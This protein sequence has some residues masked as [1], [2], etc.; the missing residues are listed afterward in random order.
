MTELPMKRSHDAT[1]EPSPKP[2]NTPQINEKD[3]G[4]LCFMNAEVP[5]FNGIIKHRYNDFHVYEVD[6]EG[7]IVHLTNTTIPTLI[8]DETIVPLGSN[9][10]KCA[11]V[12]LIMDMPDFKVDFLKMVEDENTKTICT[13]VFLFN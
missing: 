3:M 6:S 4:I 10:E 13:P 12:A 1:E 9:D 5:A 11:Q 8:K 2:L 7:N